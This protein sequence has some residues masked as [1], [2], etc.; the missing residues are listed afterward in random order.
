MKRKT[1]ALIN[2]AHLK[3]N[4]ALTKKI[5]GRSRIMAVVKADAYGHGINVVCEALS[6]ADTFAV[7]CVDE[8]LELRARG[9]RKPI[10]VLQG[11]ST[12]AE[13]QSAVTHAIQVVVHHPEQL[14][15][16]QR[17][18][19]AD[20]LEIHL[21]LDTGMGRLGFEPSQFKEIVA[22]LHTILT[23]P[24]KITVMT[25][26]ACADELDNPA[27]ERQLEAFDR[28]LG[29]QQY[30]RSIANSAALLAWPRTHCDWVR[31]GL[32]LY[33]VNPFDADTEGV[34]RV[35]LHPVMSLRAPIISVK[36]CRKG[37]HIGYGGGYRCPRDMVTG[38]VAAGYA[39]GYPRH[40]KRTSSV[41]ICGR[42]APV[43]GRVSMDMIAV[44]LTSV[45]ART[46]DEVELWGEN[47]SVAE[48]AKNAETISYELLCAAGNAVFDKEYV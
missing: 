30:P 26:L 28:A 48:I 19:P 20:P 42:R 46:G 27:T 17:T 11:F 47:I 36:T 41:F 14:K 29:Q 40:M 5:V 25:H 44:D 39:D 45:D 6:A 23:P 22:E 33:G 38:I 32:M 13:L 43:V 8:A 4:L 2:L 21:K 1:R 24:P 7:S 3:N 31:P 12:A 37:T 16:L 10:V 18:P 15:I 34:T 35:K 9:I